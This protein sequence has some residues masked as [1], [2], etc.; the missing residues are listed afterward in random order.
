MTA[1]EHLRVALSNLPD[2]VTGPSRFGTHRNQAWFVSG[3]E[4]AHLHADDLVD[5]RLPRRIQASLAT[6]TLARFRK[7]PS[8][9]VE[10]E[11]HSAVDVERL[12]TLARAAWAAAREPKSAKIRRSDV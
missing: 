11:F 4:F 2:V 3:R 6:E 10:F 8:E 9:W 1:V 12:V 5:L 7:S